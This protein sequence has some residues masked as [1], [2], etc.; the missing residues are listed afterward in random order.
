M[1]NKKKTRKLRFRSKQVEF[2]YEMRSLVNICLF[3]RH[4][5]FYFM[6]LFYLLSN[7]INIINFFFI[8][9]RK[10]VKSK[11]FFIHFNLTKTLTNTTD[12][13]LSF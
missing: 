12:K 8:K 13:S 3:D 5:S 9:E 2:I 10:E 11:F 6:A 4:Q 1:S 7:L